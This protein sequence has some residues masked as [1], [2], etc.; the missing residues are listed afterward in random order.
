MVEKEQPM[1]LHLTSRRNFISG[2]CA[3]TTTTTS[4]YAQHQT[5]AA[6]AEL[7]KEEWLDAFIQNKGLGEP[8]HVSRFVERIY[9]LTKPIAWFPNPGQERYRRVD[10]PVG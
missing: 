1:G 7:S 6:R 9:F 2:L 4:C 5:S 8:L 3:V 10:V